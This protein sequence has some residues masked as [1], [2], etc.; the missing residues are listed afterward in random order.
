[1]G[2]VAWK[3]MELYLVIPKLGACLGGDKVMA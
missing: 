2:T 3:M 1:M